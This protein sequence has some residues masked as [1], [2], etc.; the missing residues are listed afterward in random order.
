MPAGDDR[1]LK[2]ADA[3]LLAGAGVI[4]LA[5]SLINGF[6]IAAMPLQRLGLSAHLMGLM[7]SI[8]LIGLSAG[9][10]VLG[11]SRPI[12]RV[13]AIAA[14]YGF[15]GGWFVYFFAAAT[16]T[17]GMFPI[18]SGQTRGDSLLEAITT[19]GLLSVAMALF[20]WCGIA[21]RGLSQ[22]RKP[23]S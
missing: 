17:G 10:S 20:T 5:A 23:R 4:L 2:D 8:A 19:G 6:L 21:L 15:C 3:R 12:S 13:A 7:G 22:M 14:V 1:S 9:W 18:A 16:G 11:L